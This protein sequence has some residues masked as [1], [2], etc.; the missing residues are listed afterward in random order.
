MNNFQAD[1]LRHLKRIRNRTPSK[2]S[3]S[4][5]LSRTE[6]NFGNSSIMGLIESKLEETAL[7][8]ENCYDVNK[9]Y[10]RQ[11]EEYLNKI[12]YGRGVRSEKKI[13]EI[14]PK[15]ESIDRQKTVQSEDSLNEVF[16]SKEKPIT[17]NN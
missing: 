4:K 5:Q 8:K 6:H 17:A 9:Y 16:L 10:S 13:S 15:V 14:K 3:S 7:L 11:C 12:G 1:P 2:A